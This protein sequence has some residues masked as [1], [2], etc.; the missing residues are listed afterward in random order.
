M[1]IHYG[2]SSIGCFVAGLMF[3]LPTGLFGLALVIYGYEA[4]LP[5]LELEAL[6]WILIGL[7]FGALLLIS[8]GFIL[9]LIGMIKKETP[10]K[11]SFIG[12][13]LNLGVVAYLVFNIFT[14]H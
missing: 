3:Y 1:K 14:N 4:M 8:T 9:S 13:F 2:K 10:R 5:F 7:T 12:F 6:L 11:Y